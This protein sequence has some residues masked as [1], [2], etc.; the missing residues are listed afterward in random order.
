MYLQRGG[1]IS[2][3][4]ELLK[5]YKDKD[6]YPFHMPGH[7]RNKSFLDFDFLDFDITEIHEMDNLNDPS[8]S[9]LNTQ[10]FLA[11]VF[12]AEDSYILVNGSTSGIIAAIASSCCQDDAILIARN[13]HRSAYSGLLISGAF[14]FF[15]SPEM[16]DFHL[17]ASISPEKVRSLLSQH[18][19]IKAVFITSPT[20]EG[21]CSDIRSIADI[22]HSFGKIL[23]VDEAHGA[24]F[25]FHSF[26]PD[27]AVHL[28]AD[29]VIQ[30]LHKTLPALTQ[31]SIV[32]VNGNRVNR[33]LLQQF[34]SFIQTSSPSYV[35]MCSIEHCIRG[36]SE[37]EDLFNT[38]VNRLC[39]CY[40]NFTSFQNLAIVNESFKE[41]DTIFDFDRSKLVFFCRENVVKK[42]NSVSCSGL[43]HVFREQF[44]IQM[45]LYG[46]NHFVAMTSVADTD[47]GFARLTR[48]I[49]YAEQH[50]FFQ[51]YPINFMYN[52]SPKLFFHPRTAFYKETVKVPLNRCESEI[53]GTFIIP[54]PPGIPIVIPGEVITKSTIDMISAYISSHIPVIGVNQNC[55][56]IIRG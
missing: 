56:N 14:P 33:V 16:S 12:G 10:K 4:Y 40:S 28:G 2:T 49:E 5:N 30:S 3:I 21:I 13:S 22:V 17:P 25:N 26:F 23:I 37:T 50:V 8:G 53:S 9:I 6:I 39:D 15:I 36:I 24:H 44:K 41:S 19:N 18:E 7:K 55:I 31:S 1:F 27:S 43:E 20:F 48:A 34:L 32:H 54:Y 46:I 47:K 11:N 29:I 45:E 38:Y 42:E 35:F 52:E 51:K